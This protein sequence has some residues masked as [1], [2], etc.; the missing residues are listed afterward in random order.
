MDCRVSGKKKLILRDAKSL[1]RRS[2]ELHHY[3]KCPDCGTYHVASDK[4]FGIKFDV[5][6]AKRKKK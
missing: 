4:N 1:V 6:K 3:Y 5:L 2:I